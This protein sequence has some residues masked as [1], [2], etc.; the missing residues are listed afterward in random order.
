MLIG[1]TSA[2]VAACC[3][4]QARCG[5]HYDISQLAMPHCSVRKNFGLVVNCMGA[6]TVDRKPDAAFRAVQLLAS[7]VQEWRYF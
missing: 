2:D 3:A 7:G 4:V 6:Y 1:V 5:P